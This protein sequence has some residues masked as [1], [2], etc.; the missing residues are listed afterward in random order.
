MLALF[1]GLAR[2]N[3]LTCIEFLLKTG[4]DI[5]EDR[6]AIFGNALLGV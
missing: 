5:E 2:A 4:G 1:A 6:D 3:R